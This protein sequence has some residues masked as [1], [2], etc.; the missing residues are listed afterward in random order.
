MASKAVQKRRAVAKL[1]RTGLQAAYAAPARSRAL[2]VGAVRDH[3]CRLT[4]QTKYSEPF[5]LR[6]DGSSHSALMSSH[7]T[8]SP[9]SPSAS[10]IA[11]RMI[12]GPSVVSTN[13]ARRRFARC[14]RS[15]PSRLLRRSRLHRSSYNLS[16]TLTWLSTVPNASSLMRPHR[17]RSRPIEIDLIISGM[18]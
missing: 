9:A 4:A 15:F 18:M 17:V 16:S 13:Y 7:R 3:P 14:G 6:Q 12:L 1:G 11:L 2:R 8:F 5:E 10:R